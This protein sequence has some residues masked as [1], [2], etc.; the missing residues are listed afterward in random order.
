[1]FIIIIVVVK[2]LNLCYKL[3]SI[4][5][6]VVHYYLFVLYLYL[7]IQ[8]LMQHIKINNC[9]IIIVFVGSAQ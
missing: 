5:T 6:V 9:I 2:L 8:L 3:F 7:T 1:M 4:V